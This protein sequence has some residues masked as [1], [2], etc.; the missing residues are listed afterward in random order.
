MS[1]AAAAILN[2][3]H[4]RKTPPAPLQNDQR[5]LL[6][7]LLRC[8]IHHMGLCALPKSLLVWTLRSSVGLAALVLQQ[9]HRNRLLEDEL[10][11]D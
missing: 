3:L 2:A 1:L 9:K 7:L 8:W 11:M 6:E 5:K 10:R 4:L